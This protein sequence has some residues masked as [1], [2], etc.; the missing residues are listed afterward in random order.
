MSLMH[1]HTQNKACVKL[2]LLDCLVY[3]NPIFVKTD[4]V[5]RN[6]ERRKMFYC[7]RN[8]L[9]TAAGIGQTQGLMLQLGI[10]LRLE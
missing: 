5:G 10:Q 6:L 2:E 1:T 9:F 3:S 4:F 8:S 7:N